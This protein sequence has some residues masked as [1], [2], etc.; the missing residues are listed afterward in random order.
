MEYMNVK[1]ERIPSIGF[2]TWS[3]TG[4]NCKKAVKDA[5][6]MGYRHIDTAQFYDNEREVGAAISES[7]VEREEIFLTTKLWKNNVSYERAKSSFRESLKKL[8]T[9]YVDL[10]LIHWPVDSVPTEE[11]VRAMNELQSTG[12]VRKIGVS[13]FSVD[14]LE[15]AMEVSETPIFT[16][17]VKYNPFNLQDSVLQYCKEEDIM[18]TAYSP[19]GKGRIIGNE[20]LSE[21]GDKY[22]K[23][24]AQVALR[25]LVQQDKVSAIPKAGSKKH[26]RENLDIFD[27][28]LNENEMK[29]IFDI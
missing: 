18:L 17:Q 16:N 6:E 27:F 5:I 9:G 26:R 28:E 19:L 2:G 13:N 12:K 8:G 7:E 22:G 15:E 1:G 11:T 3:L 4:K 25:W 21:I 20:K 14:Q 24:S 29:E 23:S 10:L